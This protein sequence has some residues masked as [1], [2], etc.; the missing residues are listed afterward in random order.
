MLIDFGRN[1]IQ[2][3]L[4]PRSL[5]R[6]L[7][8]QLRWTTLVGMATGRGWRRA[9]AGR[10]KS[11]TESVAAD[12]VWSAAA[13]RATDRLTSGAERWQANREMLA[14][15]TGRAEEAIPAKPERGY[16]IRQ[17]GRLS[18]AVGP[19]CALAGAQ[20]IR[21]GRRTQGKTARGRCHSR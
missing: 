3:L 4:R 11:A 18:G 13:G 14:H 12:K 16:Q 10:L 17:A 20:W 15:T 2:T 19:P 8:R 21:G 1:L 9:A 7:W 5:L 6:H